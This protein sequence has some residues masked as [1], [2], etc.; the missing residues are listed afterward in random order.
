[1]NLTKKSL[2]H[3]DRIKYTRVNPNKIWKIEINTEGKEFIGSDGEP[4]R[5]FRARMSYVPVK[6]MYG[7][8]MKVE[9]IR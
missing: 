8:D 3:P 6:K 9:Y 7:N 1:M 2:I 5:Y 4:H